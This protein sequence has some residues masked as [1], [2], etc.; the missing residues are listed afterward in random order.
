MKSNRSKTLSQLNKTICLPLLLDDIFVS[1]DNEEHA[2]EINEDPIEEI[3][4][5]KFT[6]NENFDL[7]CEEALEEDQP[8]GI[9]RF[10]LG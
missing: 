5:N 3:K 9:S 10:I 7:T 8:S 6:S 2:L 1:D 4:T